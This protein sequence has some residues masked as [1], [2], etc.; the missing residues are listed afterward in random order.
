MRLKPLARLGLRLRITL[1]FAAA[2]ALLLG[3]LGLFVYLRVEGGLD[4]SLNQGLRS[5]AEDVRALVMQADSGLKQA[6]RNALATPGE[7]F[8]QIIAADGRV[9]DGTPSL[10]AGAL[11]SPTQRS[12]SS[13]GPILI[14]RTR[15]SG[16]AGSSRLLAIPVQ[17]QGQRLIV[18]VGASLRERDSA[19]AEL[20]ALLLLGGPVALLLASLLGYA[21]AGL[22]LRSVESMRRRALGISLG[23]P[24]ERLPVP[25]GNDEL[26]RL[27]RTL[28]EML[29]RNEIAFQR[30]RAFVADASH[31]LRS[32]LAILRAELDVALM[33]DRSV[34]ELE[35]AVAAAAEEADRLSMLAEDLLTLAQA[36]QG[37]LR[38]RRETIDISQIL[39]RLSERYEPRAAAAGA[40]IL[41]RAPAG[42]ELEA[43][44]MRVE[45]ALGNLLDNALR[46]GAR[47]VVLEAERRGESAELHVR[48]DGSGF[49]S[50]FIELAF[51]RFARADQ[52]R[53]TPGAGLGLSIVRSIAR[54]HGGEAHACNRAGGGAHVWLTIQ[55]ASP[56]SWG[57]QETFRSSVPASP[58]A[59]ENLSTA[60][61][62]R[63]A[64]RERLR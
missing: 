53:T 14:D 31:E 16:P 4:R 32:P 58:H 5:R 35:G 55:G 62:R 40:A 22:A 20:R 28:N 19:L 49:P 25:Q 44:P 6:G 50:R 13:R 7:R 61:D 30:E 2:I 9:L 21:V 52:T 18:V 60:P 34:Q 56:R 59:Q 54:A 43:D 64:R 45:Q 26:A 15:V 11:L 51:E 41:L 12:R 1:V 3:A 63:P 42:L 38:I 10:P 8:A 29:A 23:Q 36:D 37:N 47:E 39:E 24:G 33:G 17:A 46:H 48:D 27:A 57:V